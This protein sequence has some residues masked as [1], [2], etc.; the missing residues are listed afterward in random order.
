MLNSCTASF[1]SSTTASTSALVVVLPTL[2]LKAL[3]ATASGTPQ[4]RRM[5]EGLSETHTHTRS[6]VGFRISRNTSVMC[7]PGERLQPVAAVGVAGS[8]HTGQQPG[9]VGQNPPA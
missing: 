2:S 1:R 3:A 8:T 9:A 4:L 6:K 7:R 5:W